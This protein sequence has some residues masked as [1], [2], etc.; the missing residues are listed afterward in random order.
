VRRLRRRYNPKMMARLGISVLTA[1][2]S[3]RFGGRWNA[4]G[5]SFTILLLAGL[6]WSGLQS[7]QAIHG[8]TIAQEP[9]CFEAI[10]NGGF[11]EG[12]GTTLELEPW[13]LEVGYAY[14]T[15]QPAHNGQFSV[16]T[17]GY[18]NAVD[19]FYQS[20]LLP[21]SL[22]SATLSYWWYMHSA[23]DDVTP[24][25]YLIVTL[26]DSQGGLLQ[27]LELI[28]N[29]GNRDSWGQSDFDL[30]PYAGEELRVHFRCLGNSQ[31]VTSFFLDDVS[32]AVCQTLVNT[33]LPLIWQT[34]L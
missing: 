11:E 26:R 29:T 16:W 20:V 19:G 2:K 30:S 5:V 7:P 8:L 33:Y 18:K 3:T 28:D 14:L 12:G 1:V 13:V 15:D 21:H 31:Y 23:D 4:R 22:D 25:D 9:T 17:G 34:G 24:Y 6:L 10:A 27:E 32:L